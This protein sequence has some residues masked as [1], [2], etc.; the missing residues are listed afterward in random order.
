LKKT[1]VII[2]MIISILVFLYILNYIR[3]IL[4]LFEFKVIIV[5]FA[6]NLTW[7]I[8]ESMIYQ[9]PQT[10]VKQDGDQ[11][12]YMYLQ[13]SSILALIYAIIDF[14]EYQFTRMQLLEPG[15]IIAGFI[16]F[17]LNTV[18]RYHS[19][20]TLG[21]Y[22]N[23]RV[24]IYQEHNLVTKGI[25]KRI[26][27]PMYLSALLNIIALSLIF[28]S[29]GALVIMLFTVLP[30]IYYRI[31]IEEDFLLT[32]MGSQYKTYMEQSNRMIPGI[33]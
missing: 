33:W 29:W 21:H 27:H 31:K 1:N 2:R 8:I 15:I 30:A 26:R 22:F 12:S 32:H 14:I 4:P 25:Y 19:I 28:S 7:S 6:I 17:G 20:T 16:I 9:G 23:L 5:F 10:M 3:D 18:I 13:L 24:A 11:R